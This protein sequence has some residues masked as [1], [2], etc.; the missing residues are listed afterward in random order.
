[1]KQKHKIYSEVRYIYRARNKITT[2]WLR[3]STSLLSQTY[4]RMVDLLN[5][6]STTWGTWCVR[7]HVNVQTLACGGLIDIYEWRDV[8]CDWHNCPDIV[9]A[10]HIPS[11]P[12]PHVRHC[13]KLPT[14]TIVQQKTNGPK[15]QQNG[16]RKYFRL[17]NLLDL[18]LS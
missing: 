8:I 15:N 7:D 4:F 2:E 9:A 10:Q 6:G 14:L 18:N 3:K 12:G 17:R 16:P 13:S 5:T 1:M 11:S